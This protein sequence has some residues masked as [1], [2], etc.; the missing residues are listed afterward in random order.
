MPAL[1]GL[2]PADLERAAQRGIDE[3]ELRRQF[4]ILTEPPP[5][6]PI[7]RPCLIGDGIESIDQDRAALCLEAHGRAIEARRM[8]YFVPAS[9]A[10]TRMFKSLL[11]LREVHWP[12]R[13]SLARREEEGEAREALRFL[14]QLDRFAF[15]PELSAA[16]AGRGLDLEECRERGLLDPILSVLLDSDGLDYANT[17]K[18]LLAFHRYPAGGRTA[19]EEHLREGSALAGPSNG[20]SALHF[21]VSPAHREAFESMLEHRRAAVETDCRTEL[22]VGFSAQ[23]PSTDTIAIDAE[24]NLFRDED[25][26]LLFRPGGHGSLIANLDDLARSGADL[27]FVKNI[28]NVVHRDFSGLVLRW[29]KVLAGRLVALQDRLFSALQEIRDEVPPPEAIESAARTIRE[30]LAIDLALDPLDRPGAAQHLRRIL[31]RPSRVCAVVRADGDPGG[32]PFWVREKDGTHSRQI[33]ETAQIDTRDPEQERAR[34]RAT[35]FSPADMVLGLK[36]ATGRP[37][38]LLRHVDR[39]AVFVAEK[40]SGGRVLKALEH[41]GL[42]NGSMA[43]W[44]TLFVEVPSRI[45]QPV[46][47][48]NDLLEPA[49]QPSED[50]A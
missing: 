33:V 16:L 49:H 21:T 19:F 39:D 18:G 44:N 35:H 5:S 38:D 25:G 47:T 45:F 31:D 48:L 8:S 27:V 43:D 9:G 26:Q 13:A 17:P 15:V 34:A 29:R 14:E 30:E 3:S 32:G 24:G 23:K 28:D 10:A 41:P 46:K 50:A 20:T 1:R 2:T 12:D 6:T 36:D 7:D 40:S 22:S 37:F 4:A 42:W 11:A